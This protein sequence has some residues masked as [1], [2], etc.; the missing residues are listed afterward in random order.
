MKVGILVPQGWTGEY[1]GWDGG[2]AWSRSL[3]IAREAE[4]LGFE[5][6][7]VYDHM[8][9]TPVPTDEPT[10]ESFTVLSALA[11]VTRRVRLGHLVLCAGYRNPALVAKIASTLDV[12]SGGRFD[13]GIGAGWKRDE[14]EAYGYGFTTLRER[15]EL[16][17]DA[18]EI[19]RRMTGPGHA[20]YRG[21]HASV[22][23]AINEPKPVSGRRF[24]IMVGGNGPRITWGLA[25]RY[26]DELNLDAVAPGRLPAAL[27]TI[28]QRCEEAGR[29][30]ATLRVSVHLWLKDPAWL[31][32]TGEAGLTH[33]EL[34]E[35]YAEAGIH[36]VM[37]LVPDCTTDDEALGRFAEAA[38]AA[39]ADLA[40]PDD[41][42]DAD[43]AA[44]RIPAAA[45]GETEGYPAVPPPVGRTTIRADV[46]GPDDA[47]EEPG[48][49]A[50]ITER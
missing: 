22:T 27:A 29:D 7:W 37:G 32:D 45:H 48:T 41:T 35:R 49:T 5:S 33:T 11:T 2:P 38:R 1:D 21:R 15:Q 9:T 36:R 43:G 39:G 28:R 30:P 25:A 6:L 16:L 40:G 26:A 20:T 8:Q 18:L 44:P 19:I 46:P 13:L 10:L 3:E 42:A 4:A 12:I 24:P 34:L 17:A 23:D 50:P 31:Q 14:Y 47:I